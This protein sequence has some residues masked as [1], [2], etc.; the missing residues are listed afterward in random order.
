M[1][2]DAWIAVLAYAVIFLPFVLTTGIAFFWAVWTMKR[3]PPIEIYEPYGDPV[4]TPQT[5]HNV[6]RVNFRKENA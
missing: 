4:E 5:M 2:N 6:R 3:N 1:T